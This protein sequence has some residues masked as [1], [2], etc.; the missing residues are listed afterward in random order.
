MITHGP[1]GYA[2][3]CRCT[4]CTDSWAPYQRAMSERRKERLERGEVQV[5]HGRYSTYTNWGCRCGAC[6]DAASE[7]KKASR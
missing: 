4:E 6:C 5:P 3:G 7:A 1:S 2:N